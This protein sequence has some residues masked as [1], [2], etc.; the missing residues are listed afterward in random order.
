[1]EDEETWLADDGDAEL[2]CAR[3]PS[4]W[5]E[6]DMDEVDE[7]EDGSFVREVIDTSVL[8]DVGVLEK[9]CFDDDDEVGSV[10]CRAS[11]EELAR[12]DECTAVETREEDVEVACPLGA[13]E[14]ETELEASIARQKEWNGKN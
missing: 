11:V 7:D 13:A 10:V 2:V 3:V 5:A 12:S 6:V 9:D 14:D 8:V 4:L 1:M